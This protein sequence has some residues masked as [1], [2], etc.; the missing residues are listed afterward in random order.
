VDGTVGLT[1]NS[2]KGQMN[3]EGDLVSLQGST[4]RLV[5][6]LAALLFQPLC[7]EK[8]VDVLD[9]PL[10]TMGIDSH[11]S[12]A[13]VRDAGLAQ[14]SRPPAHSLVLGAAL[15]KEHADLIQMICKLNPWRSKAVLP[16]DGRAVVMATILA[17]DIGNFK[18]GGN[19]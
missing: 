14:A 15:S 5:I 19:L 4:L 11:R 18:S 3:A 12:H 10:R 16:P 1:L 2:L 7:R 17:I 9:G 13:G 8:Y 6:S